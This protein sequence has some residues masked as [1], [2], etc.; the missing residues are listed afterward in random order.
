MI[1][2]RHS[3]TYYITQKQEKQKTLPLTH[4]SNFVGWELR[5][6]NKEILELSPSP[7]D[8]IRIKKTFSS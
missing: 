7:C 6:K 3:L 1:V 5:V 4:S 8:V 2:L